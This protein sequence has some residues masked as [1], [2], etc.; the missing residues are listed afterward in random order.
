MR[1]TQNALS[2]KDFCLIKRACVLFR[3]VVK[4]AWYSD[5]QMFSLYKSN[6]MRS[7]IKKT[8]MRLF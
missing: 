5:K 3:I 6:K 1:N 8:R 4:V 2:E 7:L